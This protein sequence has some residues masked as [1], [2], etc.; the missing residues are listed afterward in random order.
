[1]TTLSATDL[2]SPYTPNGQVQYQLNGGCQDQFVI[3]T[4]NG[5]GQV[6][7]ATGITLT[8]GVCTLNVRHSKYCNAINPEQVII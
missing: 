2:D 8:V 5:V 1:V 7:V 3:N 6:A 4:V